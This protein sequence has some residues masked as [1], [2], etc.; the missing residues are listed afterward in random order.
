MKY[1]PL[2]II[3][4]FT[5][6]ALAGCNTTSS[7]ASPSPTT[8]PVSEG[9]PKQATSNE[10]YVFG[11][12]NLPANIADPRGGTTTGT[13]V[14][15]P[16][17]RE[18]PLASI[19]SATNSFKKDRAAILSLSGD[20]KASFHFLETMG[21]F[22][23]HKPVRPYHSWTT[24]QVRILED[25]GNFISLQH[26]LVMYFHEEDGSVMGPMVMKHWRQDW[27]YEDTD[28]HTFRGSGTWE[29]ET[30][31]PESVKGAWSQAVWQ[32]DDS[33]R[34][35]A[36]GRWTHEGNR[37]VWTGENSWRPLPRREYSVRDD[38]SVMEGFHRIAITP[39][40]WVHEQNNWKRVTG[41]A[42]KAKDY[43]GHELGIDRYELI[44][45]PSLAAADVYWSMTGPYWAAVRTAWNAVY[46]K[47]DRF[48][49]ETK[50]ENRSQFEYHFEY[51][52]KLDAGE[53]WNPEAGAQFAR[54]TIESF[55]SDQTSSS[56][57]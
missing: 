34:Y 28:L 11:W 47:R 36:I 39:T 13:P 46:A 4:L 30:R 40:G 48:A 5:G 57:Y 8:P 17:P 41:D 21:L 33:P 56:R 32:V 16:K 26:T 49:L 2:S 55:L 51:A 24:E 44:T 14:T 19:V 52:G 37:S 42:S 6:L 22:S 7:P 50:Y 18:L 43:R 29:R 31:P 12:G 20:Y 10:A 9:E 38:Y 53:S 54:D 23:E 3:V 15:F 45:S 1:L 25:S 27:T 35:E